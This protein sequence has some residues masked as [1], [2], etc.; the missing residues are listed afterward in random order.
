MARAGIYKSEVVRARQAL[1]AQGRYPSIDAVRIELGNTGS[2]ATIHRYLKEIEEEEGGATGAKVAISEALQD[3]V[4]RLAA[5]VQEE[6]DERIAEVSARHAADIGE[7]DAAIKSA[8]QEADALRK[9]LE[10]LEIDLASE[11]AAQAQTSTRL[12][13][14]TIE[15]TQRAQRVADL[16]TQLA[17]AET[18]RAS[19]EEKHENARAALEHFRAAVREQRDREN[20]QHDQQVSALQLELRRAQDAL[21]AKQAKLGEAIQDSA[22]AASERDTALKALLDRDARIDALQESVSALHELQAMVEYQRREIDERE[23]QA[24]ASQAAAQRM[25]VEKTDHAARI[26]ALEQ[27][28]A[29]A[30]AKAGAQ[31]AIIADLRELLALRLKGASKSSGRAANIRATEAE[32]PKS[33]AGSMRNDLLDQ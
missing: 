22:R 12:Q 1:L 10:R 17:Q 9:Q 20:Q 29:V 25:E 18:F 16:E 4:G 8:Q 15:N 27:Q 24:A 7:R 6:A 11:R 5:R 3:L 13:Q 19:L 31:E 21:A 33:Q 28:L 2:K 30:A 32:S 26:Q 23:R 14:A